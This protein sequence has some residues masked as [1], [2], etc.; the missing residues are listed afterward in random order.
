MGQLRPTPTDDHD[1]IIQLWTVM[2]GTNGEGLIT[3]FETLEEDV[4][5]I[6]NNMVTRTVCTNIQDR[7]KKK[8]A[9]GWITV[10]RV[11]LVVIALFGTLAGFGLFGG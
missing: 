11:A 8:R 4:R 5:E 10:E 1:A 6:K 9:T 7:R 3:R 2:I